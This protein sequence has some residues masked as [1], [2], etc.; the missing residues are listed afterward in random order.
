MGKSVE[1]RIKP[2]PVMSDEERAAYYDQQL[3]EMEQLEPSVPIKLRGNDYTLEYNNRAV[4]EIFAA[5]GL[6]LLSDP[7]GPHLTNPTT[8]SALIYWGLKKHHP[9]LTT[10]ES[11]DLF[12]PRLH[13][14]IQ[15][16]IAKA[17]TLFLPDLKEMPPRP[18]EA[19]KASPLE[20]LKPVDGSGTGVQ[21][22]DSEFLGGSF[23]NLP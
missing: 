18:K 8:L 19:D 12:G 7:L 17:M 6:N 11:D 20:L 1:R 5:T 22:D 4:K 15:S 21:P 3:M 9:D 13:L 14:Y 16:R 23:G 10:E 2:A